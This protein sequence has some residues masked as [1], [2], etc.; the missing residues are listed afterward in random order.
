MIPVKYNV[1]SLRTRWV[2]SSMTVLG[3][4]LV[5]WASVLAFGLADG[6]DHTLE[7]SGEPLDL[8]VMRKGATAETNS[9][10]NESAAREMAAL[11]GIASDAA[12][13]SLCSPELVVVVNTAR[14]GDN[15]SGNM[16]LR[17][18]TPAAQQ[19][20]TGFQI[21]EGRENKPGVREAITS[22]QMARRFE[23]AG[24][25][26]EL[27]VFGSMFTIVGLFEAGH[28]ATESEV[29]T[30]LEVLAQTSQARRRPVVDLQI[31]RAN[32]ADDAQALVDRIASDEQFGLAALSEPEYFAEQAKS[33]RAIKVVGVFIA[34]V[35]SIGAV[36]AVA[37]HHV[38][39][40]GVARP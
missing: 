8:I 18:V 29:W 39:R 1:R 3:T 17:G 34:V 27:D 6:L 33:S 14:R 40:R 12:G 11:G 28:S 31:L 32:S 22:R 38:W 10:I 24:L 9:I 21:V 5:V 26:E 23:G 2:S 4:G 20:R 37:Q 13:D 7:V 16:I 19:V 35:L 25:N 30:D 15:G 36:F